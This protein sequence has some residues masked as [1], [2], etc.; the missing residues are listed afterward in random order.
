[1]LAF[2]V[3]KSKNNVF[4]MPS[5]V[6]FILRENGT[7]LC[8][9]LECEKHTSHNP[10]FGI[11]LHTDNNEAWCSGN[12]KYQATVCYDLRFLPLDAES[13]QHHQL[14][15][16]FESI[17]QCKVNVLTFSSFERAIALYTSLYEILIPNTT[18]TTSFCAMFR[19]D[20]NNMVD[21]HL[22][23]S[24]AHFLC[25]EN[26][27]HEATWRCE[28]QDEWCA[29]FLDM[30]RLYWFHDYVMCI[31]DNPSTTTG[32]SM[33]NVEKAFENLKDSKQYTMTHEE[34][35]TVNAKQS[36]L[37]LL[38]KAYKYRFT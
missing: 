3:Y 15:A 4:E 33:S 20:T 24:L 27:P 32:Y 38:K 36:L 16:I 18:D 25:K 23:L 7:H 34:L 5:F 29:F 13:D 17:L 12:M 22:R 21:M 10:I 35:A 1:M 26:A 31:I 6:E 8:S 9:L 19:R 30:Q 11:V 37:S 2:D 14:I 28:R